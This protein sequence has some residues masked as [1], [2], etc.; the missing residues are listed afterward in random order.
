MTA[1]ATATT[2]IAT[3]ATATTGNSTGDQV[4]VSFTVSGVDFAGLTSNSTLQ[5]AFED[6]MKTEVAAVSGGSVTAADVTIVLCEGSVVVEATINVPS[7]TSASTVS[8]S[9]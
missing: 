1:T 3:T 7:G 9:V 8:S 6:Q 2:T 4:V 5:A